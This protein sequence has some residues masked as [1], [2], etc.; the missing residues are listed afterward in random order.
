MA[1]YTETNNSNGEIGIRQYTKKEGPYKI[2]KEYLVV[3]REFSR[4]EAIEMKEALQQQ[5]LYTLTELGAVVGVFSCFGGLAGAVVGIGLGA[6]LS[7]FGDYGDNRD[8]ILE[9]FLELTRKEDSFT[10][11]ITYTRK[12]SYNPDGSKAFDNWIIKSMSL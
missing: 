9:E 2:P 1:T 8:D 4:D 12:I 3:K 5:E 7:L 6:M 10:M 11:T